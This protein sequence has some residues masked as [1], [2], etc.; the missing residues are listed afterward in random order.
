AGEPRF[1]T[2]A[3]AD[4][5]A[6]ACD[7]D[8]AWDPHFFSPGGASLSVRAIAVSPTGEVYVG[9]T[10]LTI[11]GLAANRIAKWNGTTWSALGSGVN[12]TVNAIAVSGTDVY[13]GGSFLTA[14]GI[15]VNRIAKWDGTSWSALGSGVGDSVWG[16]GVSGTT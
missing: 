8:G 3:A 1:V 10:F 15:A 2:A 5:F 11:D 6:P 12:S 9:G 16:L 7:P 13:V 4:S 14:G